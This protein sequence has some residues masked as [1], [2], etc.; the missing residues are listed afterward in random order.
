[1]GKFSE[2]CRIRR[3]RT[4]EKKLVVSVGLTGYSTV[5]MAS[6]FVLTPTIYC[7][8]VSILILFTRLLHLDLKFKVYKIKP[9]FK[10]V[11]FTVFLFF[12]KS[13]LHPLG[14]SV[15]NFAVIF[16]SSLSLISHPLH[17]HFI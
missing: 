3:K 4:G 16:D 11:P 1:M 8:S 17:Q 13:Q 2:L 12:Y 10:V 5:G 15:Q 14:K 7:Y 9:V 6:G